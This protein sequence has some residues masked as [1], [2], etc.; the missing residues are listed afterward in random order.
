[1][2]NNYFNN[3]I[4]FQKCFFLF[5]LFSFLKEHCIYSKGRFSE[6]IFT[7][8][9]TKELIY[10]ENKKESSILLTFKETSPHEFNTLEQFDETL[11]K[12]VLVNNMG[13]EG[14]S[15]KLFLRDPHLKVTIDE[16]KSPYRVVINIFDQFYEQRRDPMTNLPQLLT[17]NFKNQSKNYEVYNE[18]MENER[19]TDVIDE[20]HSHMN[21]SSSFQE[22]KENHSS[23]HPKLRKLLQPIPDRIIE[24]NEIEK[25]IELVA[26]GRGPAWETFPIFVY[27]IQTASF[28]GR[29]EP[30]GWDNTTDKLTNSQVI[31]NFAYK[32]HRFGHEK[33]ALAAY[34]Q[35]LHQD[36]SIFQKDPLHLWSFAEAHFSHDNLELAKGYYTAIQNYFPESLL[37]KYAQLRIF[38]INAMRYINNDQLE[39]FEDLG[40]KISD[41]ETKNDIELESQK[42]IRLAYLTKPLPDNFKT[43]LPVTTIQNINAM[44]QYIP[45]VISKVTSFILNSIFLYNILQT[46]AAWSDSYIKETE[47]YLKTY[48]NITGKPFY[49]TIKNLFDK[50]IIQ[51]AGTYFK[52]QKP[53]Q[54]VAA[55]EK[56]PKN[57]NGLTASTAWQV[58]ESYRLL[59]SEDKSIDLYKLASQNQKGLSR[60]KSLFWITVNASRAAK[61]A[62][63]QNDSELEN[64]F[65]AISNKYD[66]VLYKDWN[67]LNNEEK[68]DFRTAYKDHLEGTLNDSVVLATPPKIILTNWDI[69][70]GT[71][72]NATNSNQETPWKEAYS[73]SAGTIHLLNSITHRFRE[74]GM[75][76]NARKATKLLKKVPIEKIKEDREAQKIW[77]E[78]LQKLAD[79]YRKE[80]EYLKAGRLYHFVANSDIEWKDR[81]EAFYKSGLLLYRS[82]KRDE[83]IKSLTRA[84]QDGENLF[85]ANLA[86]ERLNQLNP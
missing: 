63:I 49:N 66:Q 42:L 71:S 27:P 3:L 5:I 84:S 20:P 43:K 23:N 77:L 40:Q 30:S 85:Y 16:F 75:A 51:L 58:A 7:F 21:E 44:Q 60:F 61:E 45:K 76:K 72:L 18:A 80:N 28:T 70:L 11:I 26:E 13:H 2:K 37:S 6:I 65:L 82:G 33:K 78:N 12:R 59:G 46:N 19:T 69:A 31:S 17:D 57:Y 62:A 55:Y 67:R 48:D 53:A 39:L 38:D 47:K 56:L 15:V 4:F 52:E 25:E 34:Q 81:A 1:M 35:V 24:A 50:R 83:A 74:L 32:M 14:S 22:Q 36:P 54:V 10:S 29:K 9:E 8:N 68:N 86:K 41:L 73:P 64:K 79:E